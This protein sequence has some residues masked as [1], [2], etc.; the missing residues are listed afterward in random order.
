FE[1]T[2]AKSRGDR[3]IEEHRPFASLGQITKQLQVIL[4][5]K[6][7]YFVGDLIRKHTAIIIVISSAPAFVGIRTLTKRDIVIRYHEIASNQP[8]TGR[9][10]IDTFQTELIYEQSVSL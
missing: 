4:P 2:I 8:P 1:F 7:D 5:T 10:D 3:G 9:Q 6:E